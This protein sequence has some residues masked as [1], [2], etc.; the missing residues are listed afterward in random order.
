MKDFGILVFGHTRATLLGDLLESIDRQGAI[1]SVDLWIDGY[2]GKTEL[3]NRVHIAQKVGNNYDVGVR[4]YHH[5]QLGFRKL[6]L[7]AMQSAVSNYEHIL[8]LED[9]CFPTRNA[10]SIFREELSSIENDPETFSVYGHPFL[11]AED[12]GY[13]TRFQG[14]GWATTADKLAPYVDR[15]V[16]CYS[17]S[18][19]D[20]LDFTRA[21]LTPEILQRL[22]VTPPRQPSYTLKTFFAWDETLAL[23]T[24]MDAKRHKVTR[25]RVI[26]NCGMGDGSAHFGEDQKYLNPPFNIIPHERVW[27]VF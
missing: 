19:Q 5:G 6:M 21:A 1:S 25:E 15:L 16:E 27:E 13:C 23:L 20:Y 22:D 12:S 3:K 7:Q 14:W 11:M 24:A 10:V 9:D 17:M 4:R 26:F 2:Q 18:E 8:F